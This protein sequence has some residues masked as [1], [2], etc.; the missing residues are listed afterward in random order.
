LEDESG[1]SKL[2]WEIDNIVGKVCFLA[3]C[4]DSVKHQLIE[5]VL[6][7]SNYV[8]DLELPNEVPIFVFEIIWLMTLACSDLGKILYWKVFHFCSK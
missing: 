8:N 5:F 1:S 6:I 4:S 3:F 2:E 7:E